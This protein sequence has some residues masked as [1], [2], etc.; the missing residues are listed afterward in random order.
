MHEGK[1]AREADLTKVATSTETAR[2]FPVEL[3]VWFSPGFPVGGFAYSQGL[4][5][6]VAKGWVSDRDNLANWFSALL[7]HGALR[8]DLILINLVMSAADENAIT[9]LA[10][11]AAA[12]QPSAERAAEAL[13]QGE[14]FRKAYAAGWAQVAGAEHETTAFSGPITLP[15]AVALAAQAHRI[16]P[17]AV[18]ETFAVSQV[19]NLVS[20]AIRLGVIGQFGAQQLIAEMMP[21]LRA[22]AG[23][24]VTATVDDLG[25]ASF[26]ADLAT[27]LHETQQP[28]LFRS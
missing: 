16:A 28:R 13:D 27:M 22:T 15:V 20:A 21:E 12:L 5:T 9:Q 2:A 7:S 25:T 14:N 11:L 17:L 8:N 10:K 6:A 3:L 19:N 1:P 23:H 4:E 24:A 18:L 26:G